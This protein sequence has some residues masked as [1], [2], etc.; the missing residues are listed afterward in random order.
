[1]KM[2]SF[3]LSIL[4]NSG[5]WR[6]S[7]HPFEKLLDFFKNTHLKSQLLSRIIIM[8]SNETWGSQGEEAEVE[9]DADDYHD[10]SNNDDA[11]KIFVSRIPAHF[12]EAS[13][14][15]LLEEH[16][17]SDAIV[18]IAL[19]A[20]VV[21]S[22]NG[23]NE[24][25]QDQDDQV[26]SA[27]PTTSSEPPNETSEPPPTTTPH[28]GF[29]FVTLASLQLRAQALALGKLRGGAKTTSTK[30]HTLYLRPVSRC[31][32][33]SNNNKEMAESTQICYLWTNHSCPYG[34]NCKFAH[35]GPGGT[36]PKATKAKASSTDET[37][38]KKTKCWN[39]RKG[40]C[41]LGSACP[42]SHDFTPDNEAAAIKPAVPKEPTAKEEKDCIKW[43]TVGKCPRHA[44]GKCP[45]RHDEHVQQ[46]ALLK[47]QEK[48]KRKRN[49]IG[50]DD[51]PKKQS[52]PLSVKVSGL[53]YETRSSDIESLFQD[54]GR[55]V[56]LLFPTFDDS[57]R[58]KG[59]CGILFPSP[60]AVQ[61]ALELSGHELHGRCLLV[62]P[63]AGK[64][65]RSVADMVKQHQQQ[66]PSSTTNYNDND[67]YYRE[68]GAV[69]NSQK[70]VVVGEFG[71]KV[72]RRKRH[73]HKE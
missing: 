41:T 71:Q 38:K 19:A 68:D 60:K 61:K 44:K 46:A 7:L 39:F 5:G 55:I 14:R 56:E 9:G 65:Y 34:T 63:I 69:D 16:L 52:Q 13:V 1:M 15:R 40:K 33:S 17:G 49:E 11:C 35:E 26:N 67:H 21:K 53:S 70:D 25:N 22:E 43:K 73:G 54:C 20:E 23:D 51:A 10:G 27:N 57:G 62:T 32:S 6:D 4:S 24:E 2:T 64:W 48:N 72:K 50:I 28:R 47:Q 29:G 37:K 66:N 42:F 30:K 59:Y 3:R 12:T 18:Q 8:P 58:S 45:Y 36:L 31:R